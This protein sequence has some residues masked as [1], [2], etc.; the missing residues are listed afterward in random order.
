MA[1]FLLVHGAAHGAWCW[2]DVVPELEKLGHVGVAIDL[3]SHGDDDT[4]PE[5]VTLEMYRDAVL[6]NC[7][8]DTVLVGHSMGGF[9]IGAAANHAPQAMRGLI[10]VCAYAPQ[11]GLSLAA[12]R[13]QAPRQP[14]LDAIHKSDDGKT[15]VIDAEKARDLFYHDCP[16]EAADYAIPL[17]CRQAILPQ[18]TPLDLCAEYV[19]V[20]KAY[21]RCTDDRTIPP[22]YQFTM[23]ADWPEPSLFELECAHSPFF[24]KPAELA[25]LLDRIERQM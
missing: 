19:A 23:T 6:A 13:R 18:E 1:R 24:A 8:A 20:P 14:L 15:F 16:P 25:G 7:T 22:G 5:T 21:I 10:F 3:P 12:M 17:L 2:R 11:S 4:P 9:P